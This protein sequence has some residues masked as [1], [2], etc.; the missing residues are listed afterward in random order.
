MQPSVIVTPSPRDNVS[1]S[2][3][4][5]NWLAQAKTDIP[6]TGN[7]ANLNAAHVSRLVVKKVQSKIPDGTLGYRN[8]T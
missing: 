5:A 3:A 1:S 2:E 4:A 8:G 7:T 6:T